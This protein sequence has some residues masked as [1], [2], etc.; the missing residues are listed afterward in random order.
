MNSQLLIHFACNPY[1]LTDLTR[2]TTNRLAHTI[3][4]TELKNQLMVPACY[5]A[6]NF[7]KIENMGTNFNSYFQVDKSVE[8]PAPLTAFYL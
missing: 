6:V 3:V 5:N 8:I 2:Q 1:E 7:G 4:S